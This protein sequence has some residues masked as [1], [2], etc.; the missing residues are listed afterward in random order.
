VYEKKLAFNEIEERLNRDVL[1]YNYGNKVMN[2]WNILP[3]EVINAN[4]INMF[5]D[6]LDKYLYN[7]L[8]EY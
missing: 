7:I 4:S 1:K 8:G 2:L 6:G 3:E 5:K